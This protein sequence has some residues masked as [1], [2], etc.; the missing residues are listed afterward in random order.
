MLGVILARIAWE[1]IGLIKQW[2]AVHR[3]NGGPLCRRSG[4]LRPRPSMALER[5]RL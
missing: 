4:L 3:S 1:D 2:P 5:L